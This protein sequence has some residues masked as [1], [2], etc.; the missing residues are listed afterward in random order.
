MSLKKL[1]DF[2]DSDMLQLFEFELRPYRSGRALATVIAKARAARG[3]QD[4]L[5]Q[6]IGTAQ[7]GSAKACLRAPA[8][9]LEGAAHLSRMVAGRRAGGNGKTSPNSP[10]VD[11]SAAAN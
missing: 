7:A 2:F 1:L 8:A 9:F 5:G 6:A 11:A 4:I 10:V 3:V